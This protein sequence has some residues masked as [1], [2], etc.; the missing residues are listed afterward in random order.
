MLFRS[1]KFRLGG[2]DFSMSIT[3]FSVSLGIYS[4]RWAETIH[5][6]NS[7]VNFPS[8][9]ACAFWCDYTGAR[10]QNDYEP[11]KFKSTCFISYII[12]GNGDQ[13]IQICGILKF[14]LEA[15]NTCI[16]FESIPCHKIQITCNLHN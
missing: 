9:C 15:C 3:Q 1:I 12:E 10:F 5:Y 4:A 16:K 11:T 13:S 14:F 8:S 7:L 6:H 2:K